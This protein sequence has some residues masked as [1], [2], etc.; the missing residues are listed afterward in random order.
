SSM[1]LSFRARAYGF[2]GPGPQL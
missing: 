2:R 1:K